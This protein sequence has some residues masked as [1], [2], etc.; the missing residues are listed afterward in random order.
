MKKSKE[1]LI[2]VIMPVYNTGRFVAEAME[3]ILSQTYKNFEFIIINDGS[4]DNTSEILHSYKTR[5]LK[6][7]QLITLKENIGDSKAANIGFQAARGEFIARMDAD[8]ISH[9]ERLARQVKY[10]LKHPGVIMLGTQAEI[11]NEDSEKTGEKIFPI[12]H[13]DIYN[14]YAIYHPMLHPSCLFR[15]ELLPNKNFLYESGYEPNDDYYTF[16]KLLNYGEFA[17]LNQK[18]L[19]YRIHSK[20]ISLQNLKKRFYN[21]LRI[22]ILSIIKLGY[23]PTFKALIAMFLQFVLVSLIPEKALPLVYM[24]IKRVKRASA[25]KTSLQ[26]SVFKIRNLLWIFA[27]N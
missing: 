21:T 25:H 23:R 3:S 20:N 18:L 26:S 8:D 5:Y 6:I 10:M 17:N 13:K 16:F 22:R 2:S 7:I 15:R 12:K 14:N 1:L 11:I 9:P 27:K 4:A 24:I 19:Y